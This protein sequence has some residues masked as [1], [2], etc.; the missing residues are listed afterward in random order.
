MSGE[1]IL[2][3]IRILD[4]TWVLA[5]PYATRL[6]ADFGAEVIKVLPVGTPPPDTPFSRAYEGAW[7]RNKRGI[8]LDPGK[9]AGKDLAERLV[10]LSDVV[11]ENFT[12]RVMANWGLDYAALRRVRPDIIMVSMSARGHDGPDRGQ[13]GFAPT[14]HAAAGLTGLLASPDGEPLGPGF[15]YADH[16]AGLYAAMAVLAALEHRDAA[17]EGQFIDISEQEALLT[18]LGG[19]FAEEAPGPAPDGVYP[20]RD[21]QWCAITVADDAAWRQFAAALGPP[22]WAADERFRTAAGRREH[23]EEMDALVSART[24]TRSVQ[25]V[26][27]LLQSRGV[28]AGPVQDA[29]DL[30]A[31]PRLAAR[32]FLLDRPDLGPL[33]D[34]SPIRLAAAPPRYAKAAPLPGEDNDYVYGGLLGLSP[35]ERSRL[36]D[37]RVI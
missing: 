5:G 32:G 36:R 13:A 20:C 19:A 24:R 18:L 37:A 21:G 2:H 12:P 35:A 25:D 9:P 15:S 22:G 27:D 8:T 30:F 10:A 1:P 33:A 23:R 29:S 26:V 14:V 31:D 17:G 6:L 16:V 34:A 3:N 4:F 7:N 11:I 28:A